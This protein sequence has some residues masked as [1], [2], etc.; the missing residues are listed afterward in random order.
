MNKL[1]YIVFILCVFA[2]CKSEKEKLTDAISKTEKELL[3]DSSQQVNRKK[4]EEII[5]LYKE[6]AAKFADDT[7]SSEYLFRAGD[8]SNGIGQYKEAIEYYGRAGENEKFS[9]HAVAFFL[10]GFIYET[11]LNDFVN[12][13]RIYEEFLHKYPDHPLASDVK[14]S[15]DNL[16]KS[17]EELIKMF[18]QNDSIPAPEDTLKAAA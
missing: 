4:A 17:P 9:K 15:L 8:I 11:Q 6:Y 10:T 16:G 5:G 1:K 14:F 3:D 7:V 13:K 12:S 18:E 2:A